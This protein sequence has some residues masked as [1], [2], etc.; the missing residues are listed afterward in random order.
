MF[1]DKLTDFFKSNGFAV[2]GA[3][4]DR[5][6][7]GNKVLRAYLQHKMWV[8]PVNPKQDMIEGLKVIHHIKDLPKDI[9][10]I[11]IITPSH[12][13]ETIVIEAYHRGINHIWIQPGAE[14]PQAIEKCKE[15]GINV[16]AGGPCIL[17]H[18][19]FKDH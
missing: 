4:D 5:S 3:S 1:T 12:I 10:S 14:S 18:L 16:I 17:V 11:S 13:T 19:G 6:K 9:T 8:I 15:L 7:Y 2:V